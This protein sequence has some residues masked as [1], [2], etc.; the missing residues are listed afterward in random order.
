MSGGR[1]YL[2]EK[3]CHCRRSPPLSQHRHDRSTTHPP[4][5]SM[6]HCTTRRTRRRAQVH[7]ARETH[8]DR[9]EGGT[10]MSGHLHPAT[11]A[12]QRL[13]AARA[14]ASHALHRAASART[15]C[16]AAP[17]PRLAAHWNNSKVASIQAALL[18][19]VPAS[20]VPRP[21]CPFLSAG[22]ACPAPAFLSARLRCLPRRA[23]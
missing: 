6:L 8:V 22:R 16:V 9:T 5:G 14:S 1:P 15:S 10:R 19:P 12:I 13:R 7:A 23:R 11:S 18:P 3:H 4:M 20:P 21:P 2:L 17:L